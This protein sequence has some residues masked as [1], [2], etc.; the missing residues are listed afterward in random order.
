MMSEDGEVNM[1]QYTVSRRSILTLQL[2]VAMNHIRA[3]KPINTS[4][5]LGEHPPQEIFAHP[6]VIPALL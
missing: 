2:Q 1:M 3:M 5:Q 4:T 6:S